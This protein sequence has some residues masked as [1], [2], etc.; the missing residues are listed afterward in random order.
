MKFGK[1]IQKIQRREW[2]GNYMSYKD[3]KKII[4]NINHLEEGKSSFSVTITAPNPPGTDEQLS[5]EMSDLKTAFFFRLECE[6]EK[7]NNFYLQKE[8]EYKLRL[9]NLIELKTI[10]QSKKNHISDE[11]L[12]NLASLFNYFLNDITKLQEF[13]E[14]NGV[15]FRKILKKWDK[16][17]KSITKDMYLAR[18]VEIQPC[19]NRTVLSEMSETATSH[20]NELK[21][22]I[23]EESDIDSFPN[24]SLKSLSIVPPKDNLLYNYEKLIVRLILSG[25]VEEMKQNLA[26][27]VPIL[28]SANDDDFYN[29]IFFRLCRECRYDVTD[30]GTISESSSNNNFEN[31][32]KNLLKPKSSAL[33]NSISGIFINSSLGKPKIVNIINIQDILNILNIFLKEIQPNTINF[34]YSDNIKHQTCL[35]LTA[36]NSQVELMKFCVSHHADIYRPDVFGRI[37]LHYVAKW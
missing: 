23:P 29:R 22:I 27:V 14:V 6:L 32:G 26:K 36:I 34:N 35:H 8:S 5:K 9:Q 7:V 25:K 21:Q 31:H 13:V 30:T 16:R 33:Q 37:P 3:L 11:S 24:Q 19:F 17:T 2:A 18:Q 4:N 12:V 10:T 1:H 20:L 15:G 28:D